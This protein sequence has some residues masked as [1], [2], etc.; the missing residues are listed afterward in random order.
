M[1]GTSGESISIKALSIPSPQSADKR[2]STVVTW[3]SPRPRLVERSVSS[4]WSA[5]AGMS[6]IGLRSVRRK[7]MPVST[8]AGL[9]CIVTLLPECSPTP[10]D[11]IDSRRVRCRSMVFPLSQGET[12]LGQAPSFQFSWPNNVH[13]RTRHQGDST[14]HSACLRRNAGTSKSCSS[15]SSSICRAACPS[16][17]PVA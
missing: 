6:R 7:T 4:T 17:P 13:C 12:L 15:R 11:L 8:G 14:P 1:I 16:T 2:C 9:N 3:N 5:R 10:V